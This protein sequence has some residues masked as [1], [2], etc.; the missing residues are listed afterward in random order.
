MR[1]IYN[2]LELLP[3]DLQGWNGNS[4][5]FR[6]IIDDINPKIIVEVGSWKGQSA[7]NMA[8]YIRDMGMSTHIYCIDT[9]LG[10]IEFWTNLKNMDGRDL[11][12]KN[13]YPQIYYQFLSNVVH[14]GV[15]DYIT[16]FPNTS[17]TGYLYCKYSNIIPDMIYID[18]SHEELDVYNDISNYYEILNN[19]G[20]IFGDDYNAWVGVGNAVRKFCQVNSLHYTILEDNFWMIKK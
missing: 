14:S 1:E 17:T 3:I 11:L 8:T 9:W 13:G 4:I 12:L 19:G 16:P 6:N 2:D 10:A 7:I 5:V 15:E 18:A 20:V